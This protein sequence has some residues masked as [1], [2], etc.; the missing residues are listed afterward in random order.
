MRVRLYIFTISVFL[1]ALG[2]SA[3]MTD[4]TTPFVLHRA[5]AFRT[6]AYQHCLTVSVAAVA[7]G[8]I[9]LL[10]IFFERLCDRI[11]TGGYLAAAGPC[12]LMAGDALELVDDRLWLYVRA[13]RKADKPSD[14]LCLA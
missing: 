12:L 11:G 3:A 2:E 14:S 8:L 5:P 7:V 4:R 13:E 9:A 1:S 10:S 6:R